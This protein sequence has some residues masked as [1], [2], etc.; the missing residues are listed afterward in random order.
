MII[1]TSDK[2]QILYDAALVDQ[3]GDH[4]FEPEAWRA[5]GGLEPVTAGRGSAWFIDDGRT[6]MVLRHYR[7]GGFMARLSEDRYLWSGREQSRPW[8]EFM[9]LAR[10]VELGL[11]VP[12]PVAARIIHRAPFYQGDLIT[13]RLPA[14]ALS[15]LARERAELPWRAIGACIRRFHEAGVFHADLNAHNILLDVQD[16]PFIIDFDRGEIRQPGPWQARNLA[17]LRRSLYKLKAADPAFAFSPADWEELLG[18]Y[19]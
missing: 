4:L 2:G 17:R 16:R 12:R 3:A 6:P 9:L 5:R 7:R 1:I 19:R 15:A 10:L 14:R 13:T 8:R 11:P 18:G